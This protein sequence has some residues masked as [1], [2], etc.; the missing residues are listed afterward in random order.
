MCLGEFSDRG[1]VGG[2]CAELVFELFAAHVVAGALS[3]SELL[4]TLGERRGITPAQQD[5][6]LKPFG[7]IALAYRLRPRQ[8]LALAAFKYMP[9]MLTPSH[10]SYS[11]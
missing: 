6:D 5:A 10:A 9:G 8:W 4:D 2:V 11:R 3:S 7:W 1:N